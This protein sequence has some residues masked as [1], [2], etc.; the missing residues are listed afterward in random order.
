MENLQ[1]G[2]ESEIFEM[3]LESMDGGAAA[4]EAIPVPNIVP[5]DWQESH[6]E[7]QLAVDIAET[8]ENIV[9]ISTMAGASPDSIDVSIHND[10]ITIR[11][12]RLFPV[13]LGDV[14]RKLHEECFWGTFSRSIV[15]PVDV[16]G[17]RARAE[18][19]NG[20]LTVIIPKKRSTS[21]SVPIVVVDE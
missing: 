15:L 8:E 10:L 7:G 20:V 19:K 17:D 18:Y 9:V 16:Y 21:S 1:K 13:D 3:I 6:E 2:Q 11:G 4:A 14:D 12:E 5:E